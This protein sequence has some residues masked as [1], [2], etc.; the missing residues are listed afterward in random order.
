MLNADR[1]SDPR[2]ISIREYHDERTVSPDFSD[3]P[4]IRYVLQEQRV[5]FSRVSRSVYSQELT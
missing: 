5:F 4:W 3:L 1:N 2:W